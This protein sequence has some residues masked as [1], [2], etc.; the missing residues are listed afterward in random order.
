MKIQLELDWVIELIVQPKSFYFD[1]YPVVPGYILADRYHRSASTVQYTIPS[2]PSEQ[3]ER[4]WKRFTLKF[5]LMF[6]CALMGRHPSEM[7]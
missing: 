6:C 3:S 1:I 7:D 2:P 4:E 5:F